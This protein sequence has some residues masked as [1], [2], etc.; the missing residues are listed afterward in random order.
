M[1]PA[2]VLRRLKEGNVRFLNHFQEPRNPYA[3]LDTTK[4]GQWPFAAIVACMDSRVSTEMVFDL[5]IGDMFSLRIA[6]NI[7][8]EGIIGSLEYA[9]AWWDQS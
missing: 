3:D 9:T 7:L 1:T 2:D 5:G 4:G 8:T 6:G